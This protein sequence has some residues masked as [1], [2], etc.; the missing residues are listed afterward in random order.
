MDILFL[1]GRI[2]FGGFF[3]MN[4]LNHL[5]KTDGLA[6]YA[7][8][9]GVPSPRVA[10]LLSGLLILLGGIGIIFGILPQVSL[11]L[12]ILFLLPVSF[13]MHAFW[14]ASPEE[15]QDEMI[16]FLKNLALVGAAL[17]LL[18]LELPWILSL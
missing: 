3:V 11:V 13:Q 9:K 8:S 17:M 5:T 10:V 7:K 1:L 2:L 14:N 15:K 4:G 18:S 12:V 16:N 6:Q